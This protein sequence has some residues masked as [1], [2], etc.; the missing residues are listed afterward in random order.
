MKKLISILLILLMLTI[1]LISCKINAADH[2][3]TVNQKDSESL[4]TSDDT[5]TS[6]T[7]ENS[8]TSAENTESETSEKIDIPE[9]TSEALKNHDSK[10]GSSLAEEMEAAALK[11]F[12]SEGAPYGYLF[13]EYAEIEGAH[14][15]LVTSNG[16]GLWVDWGNH[17]F[18]IENYYIVYSS[19]KALSYYIYKDGRFYNIEDA[20]KENI[21]S[22][23][24]VIKFAE[25]TA[26]KYGYDL[27]PES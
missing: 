17:I 4:S 9:E 10:I 7:T 12:G 2:E 23:D 14:A 1:T 27:Y 20:Y 21:L 22:M 13:T 8:I 16:Y 5:L 11:Q 25:K 19:S 24:G 18:K 3:E 6:Q 26:N 15:C